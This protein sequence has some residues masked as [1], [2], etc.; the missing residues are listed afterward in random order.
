[1]LYRHRKVHREGKSRDAGDF[2]TLR[3]RVQDVFLFDFY[4]LIAGE[5]VLTLSD[6]KA[7]NLHQFAVN[8]EVKAPLPDH[9]LD[10]TVVSL[11]M[12]IGTHCY[13]V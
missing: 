10:V 5:G 8:D 12:V 6:S 1:M 11:P 2:R 9:H 7:W 4:P 13:Y 3:V